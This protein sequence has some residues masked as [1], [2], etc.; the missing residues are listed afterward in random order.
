MTRTILILGGSWFLG[1]TIAESAVAQGFEVSTFRRGVSGVDVDGVT[2]LRG[3]RTNPD[4]LVRLASSGTWDAV[5]DTSSYI[6]RE[7]LQLARALEPVTA[8]YVLV[9]TVS[10]YEGWPLDPLTESSTVLDCPPDAGPDFGYDGD[11]GPS[12]YGFGKAGCENAVTAVFGSE[13]TTI[14]RPGV[15]L[16]PNEYVG[17]LEWWLRRMQR[18]GRIL[19]PGSP[20]RF[21]QPIDVR[22]VASFALSLDR[23]GI[24][25]VASSGRETMGDMLGACRVITGS[26]GALEWITD[27]EWL[28]S[29]RITQWT[30]LPLWRT[31]KGAWAVDS[32]AARAAG[33]TCRPVAET[34]AD[35]WAWLS[36]GGAA[37]DHE[38]AGELGI[39]PERER[40]VL[41]SWDAYQLDHCGA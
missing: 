40:A 24:W 11:P 16:G 10:V 4:D 13:R 33:L 15:I 41:E 1:R 7:T 27:E 39:S 28:A 25:N 5:I 29:Q 36:D 22:D 19:A 38:R 21:V 8:R 32:T 34:V 37:I 20:S 6:P 14:L 30:E 23:G 26:G 17:R 2:T 3:D 35:T 31:Y 12:K 9:S 18:G